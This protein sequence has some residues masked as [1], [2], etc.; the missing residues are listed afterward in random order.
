MCYL[1][2]CTS[3]SKRLSYPSDI[4]FSRAR[5]SPGRGRRSSFHMALPLTIRRLVVQ[6]QAMHMTVTTFHLC[7][8]IKDVED[9]AQEGFAQFS[10]RQVSSPPFSTSFLCLALLAAGLQVAVAPLAWKVGPAGIPTS[11]FVLLE[12][13]LGFQF[14]RSSLNLCSTGPTTSFNIM[15]RKAKFLKK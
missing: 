10:K 8:K 1:R 2:Q 11:L 5:N 13:A 9:L 7:S 12:D 4:V 6:A 15:C 14:S 3:C